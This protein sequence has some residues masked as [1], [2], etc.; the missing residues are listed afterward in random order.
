MSAPVYKLYEVAAFWSPSEREYDKGTRPKVVMGP[1]VLLAKD[2]ATARTLAAREI[3]D[4][5]VDDIDKVTI[6]VRPF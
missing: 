5:F 3:P 4:E 6:V 1:E 2:D